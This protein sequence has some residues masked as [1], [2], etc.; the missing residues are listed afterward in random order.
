MSKT[1]LTSA[2]CGDIDVDEVWTFLNPLGKYQMIQTTLAILISMPL[3]FSI[4]GG[5]F[6]GQSGTLGDIT[7]KIYLN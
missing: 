3:S 4:L 2:Q 1:D 6:T 7:T 5:V